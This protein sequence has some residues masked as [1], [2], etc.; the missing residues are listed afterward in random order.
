MREKITLKN[1]QKTKNK[2]TKKERKMF[3]KIVKKIKSFVNNVS[4]NV[5][6][7][8]VDDLYKH[9]IARA[10][11]AMK[12]ES[13]LLLYVKNKGGEFEA[14]FPRPEPEDI[15]WFWREF[16]A[17]ANKI[18]KLIIRS[19]TAAELGLKKLK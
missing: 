12:T 13:S 4:I 9:T 19:Y 1:K 3:N 10:E 17:R 15:L 2:K 6:L 14:A 16:P 11:R 7:K 8:E 18:E 5:R